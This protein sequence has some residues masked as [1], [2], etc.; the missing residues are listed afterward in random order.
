MSLLRASRGRAAE[1]DTEPLG[2]ETLA[3]RT[4]ML[5]TAPLAP[6]L[7]RLAAPGLA[8]AVARVTFLT[9]DAIFVSWLGSE[10]L[11]AVSLVFPFV[12]I[13]QTA[14]AS[15]FGAG[16]S[17]S[18]GQAVG[19]G[20]RERAHRL[21][22]TA[23]A[24]ALVGACATSAAM[25]SLGPNLY[26]SMG[27]A[28]PVLPLATSYSTTIFS[29]IGAIWLMNILANVARGVG[30]MVTPALALFAGECCH[31]LLSPALIFGW[32][33]F[34][35][36]GIVG[37]A[38]G[39]LSAY[40]VGTS[41]LAFHLFSRR[42]VVRLRLRK[43]CIAAREAWTLLRI[44]APAATS[45]CVFWSV[46]LFTIVLIGSLG[47]GAIAAYGVATRLDNLQYPIVFAIGA[48]VVTMVATATGADERRRAAQAAR[49][50]CVV[51]AMIATGFAIVALCGDA[52]MSIFTTDP[53]IRRIGSVYLHM[54]APVYP[55][56]AAGI[57]AVMACYGVSA[58][59]LP[60]A[61]N[62]GRLVLGV[63]GGWIAFLST[64][65]AWAV[66]G[67]LAAAS[68]A[69]GVAVIVFANSR[70]RLLPLIIGARA[71]CR[72]E[73]DPDESGA[74][75]SSLVVRALLISA[76]QSFARLTQHP[77]FELTQRG[78]DDGSRL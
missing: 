20:E 56:F 63:G 19:G 72:A 59:R 29:G 1:I 57:V 44:G 33:P 74:P 36:L 50:G 12:L 5:L 9:A 48:S 25:L 66:F 15:G 69:Y 22:G 31:L 67:M 53:A 23:V 51:A 37:A 21:A 35:R 18:I 52:W 71:D 75:R 34:A 42:P 3:P 6:T 64:K 4:Q 49:V 13:I 41:I 46:N 8:E 16:V 65:Q 27:A 30:N 76:G 11:A 32:G 38:L 70:F 26:R 73:G 58:V 14:T 54:Q 17:S 68:A 62:L 2:G 40:A 43:I 28:G 10:A 47:R 61:V 55:I 24:L 39:T 7:L 60:L 78:N 77:K 45:V